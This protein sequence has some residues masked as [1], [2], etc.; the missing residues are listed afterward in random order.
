[1]VGLRRGLSFVRLLRAMDDTV[2]VGVADLDPERVERTCREQQV[3]QGF[4]SLDGLLAAGL[5]LLVVATPPAL[6][7][8][9]SVQAL[10]AGIH[11]LSEV[12]ALARREEADVLVAAVERSGRQYM[13]AENCCFWAFV[14]A[15]RS[16]Y[17]RGAFGTLFYAEAEYI[18]HIPTLRRDAQGRPTWRADMEP[19]FYCTHSLGPLLW[20]GGQYPV[21]V[22]CYGSGAH[23]DAAVP[24]LQTALL[25]LNGGGIVRLTCSFANAHWGG[26][27]YTLFGTRASLDTGWVGRDQPRFWSADVP[28]LQGPIPLPI[29]TD[30]PGLAAAARLGGH[31]TAE[32]RLVRAFVEA[33]R[34]GA[35]PP[36]DVYTALTYSLP[37][38]CAQEAAV[39]GKPIAVPRYQRP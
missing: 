10:D 26:H 35:P 33:I 5:D 21:E 19:I 28:H 39:Q 25:R 37:G 6:H 2:L 16:L 8:P 4:S 15:A 31:G 36:I 32:W 17:Q 38:L 23:F 30:V 27:R 3:A 1:V 22:S 34:A 13:L 14:E 12:P 24:D 9:Q 18:H 7:V 11:V 20:I 29:G